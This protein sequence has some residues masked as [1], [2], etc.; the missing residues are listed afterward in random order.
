MYFY[1]KINEIYRFYLKQ[2]FKIKKIRYAKSFASNEKKKYD[3]V[4]ITLT[5]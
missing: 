1:L 3:K 4:D 5:W 2:L